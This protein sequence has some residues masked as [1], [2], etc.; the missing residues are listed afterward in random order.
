MWI[1]GPNVQPSLKM[2]LTSCTDGEHQNPN[3][4]QAGE[5]SAGKYH[6]NLGKCLAKLP[7]ST[8]MSQNRKTTLTGYVT[9]A[10]RLIS[11]LVRCTRQIRR[12]RAIKL[13]E[14]HFVG[15]VA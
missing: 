11:V 7:L 8:K 1:S 6:Y 9:E 15:P 4:K 12:R 14:L 5:K 10:S 3:E 13:D 2:V